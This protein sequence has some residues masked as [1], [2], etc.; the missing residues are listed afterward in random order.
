IFYNIFS[1]VLLLIEAI[2]LN[3]ILIK[4]NF[5]FKNSYLPALFYVLVNSLYPAMLGHSSQLLAAFFLIVV[6]DKLFSLYDNENAVTK[7]IDAGVFT[8]IAALFSF[9]ALMFLPFVVYSVASIRPFKLR[10]VVLSAC[11]LFIPLYVLAVIYFLK[12]DVE[13][14]KNG[15]FIVN[16]ATNINAI[17]FSYEN[18]TP[19]IIALPLSVIAFFMYQN[20]IGRN[21]VKTR[22]IQNV[23]LVMLFFS[24]GSAF[25]SK[26]SFV[27]SLPY[28]SIPLG[29]I[30]SYYFLLERKKGDAI[31][32]IIF[33]ALAILIIVL[34][35]IK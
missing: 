34:Q 32:E 29:I 6:L 20:D 10:E 3:Y 5:F 21:N 19:L 28:I 16:T 8:G 4:H 2:Y 22:K 7:I 1:L 26:P 33:G 25:F 24:V 15:F 13:T 9:D 31:K 30:L 14:V 18:I 17:Q 23:V 11:G 35:I 12:G 27:Y